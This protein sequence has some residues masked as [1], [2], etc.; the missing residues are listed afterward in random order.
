MKYSPEEIKLKQFNVVHKGLNE[1]EVRSYLEELSN[2]LETLRREKKMLEQLIADK[3]EN[4][5]RF[6]NVE[7][8]ISDAILVAQRAG[9]EIK[10][11]AGMQADVI[12]K[13]AKSH[14]D[15]IVNDAMQK[16]REIAYQTED[17]KRQSKIFRSRF[18]LLVEAQL[19]LLKTEDWDYL[20]NYDLDTRPL[21]EDPEVTQMNAA[22][23]KGG[24]TVDKNESSEN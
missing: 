5:N 6:K 7:N 22:G 4:I 23:N 13:D 20:L 24:G 8:T 11:S 18:Q 14:A 10:A 2:E 21:Q 12:I 16:A 1:N 15:L 3:D 19:D 9:D 17:M